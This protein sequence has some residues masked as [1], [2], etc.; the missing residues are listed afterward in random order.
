MS[1]PVRETWRACVDSIATAARGRAVRLLAVSKS[2]PVERVRAL[3]A[4]GQREFGE[5]YVQEALAKIS[6]CADLDLC[7]HF[8]GPLQSNKCREVA[9]HFDWLHS[10]D[11]EKLIPALAQHRP[12]ERPPLNVLLQVNVEAEPGKAGCPPDQVAVLADAVATQPRLRLRGLMAIPVP[13]PQPEARRAAFAALRRL[14]DQLR[15]RHPSMDTLSIG[16][17]DDYP[18]AIA[19]GSTLVRLGTALFGSRSPSRDS[20]PQH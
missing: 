13:Q 6:A 4:V 9:R 10:L 8:I 11:R 3:A 16:M 14:F 20:A 18:V 17:S 15:S 1:D 19:E 5:N 7:W 12:P 2:Q